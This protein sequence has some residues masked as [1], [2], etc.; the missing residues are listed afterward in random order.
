[1]RV[2]DSFR[3]QLMYEKCGIDLSK[4]YHS[5]Y[6]GNISVRY[7]NGNHINQVENIEEVLLSLD[8]KKIYGAIT[9]KNDNN[10]IVWWTNYYYELSSPTLIKI[11]LYSPDEYYIPIKRLK[12]KFKEHIDGRHIY[13]AVVVLIGLICVVLPK[14]SE[15]VN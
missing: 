14:I 5:C 4:I 2:I 10:D 8:I 7:D 3:E 1:M 15:M 6:F 11:K 12:T 13:L 9:L